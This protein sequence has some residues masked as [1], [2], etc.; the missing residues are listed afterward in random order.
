MNELKLILPFPPSV[1]SAYRSIVRGKFATVIISEKGRDYIK[2]VANK[3]LIA[4][5]PKLG[6]ARLKVR[7]DV[8]PPDRRKRDLGNLDKL[9]FDSLQKAGVFD[10]DSQIDDQR[11]VRKEIKKGGFV[12]LKFN[13]LEKQES[14]I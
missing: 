1:N 9:L 2:K 4:G 13:V 5:S 10:D 14:L 11:F 12:L 3:I 6:D 7:V 8:Y